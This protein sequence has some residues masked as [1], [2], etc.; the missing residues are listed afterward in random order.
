[1]PATSKRIAHVGLPVSIGRRSALR[2]CLSASQIVDAA[3]TTAGHRSLQTAVAPL[4]ADLDGLFRKWM[5]IAD[6]LSA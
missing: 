3:E 5:R 1:L 6:D 4:L 2:V